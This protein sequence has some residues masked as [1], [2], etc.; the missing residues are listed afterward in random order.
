MS[1]KASSFLKKRTKKLLFLE[2]WRAAGT[3]A[4]VQ[5]FFASVFQK[6]RPYVLARFG[7][8]QG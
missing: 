1:S 3:R 5:K 6:G 7:Q 8:R 4:N 2:R